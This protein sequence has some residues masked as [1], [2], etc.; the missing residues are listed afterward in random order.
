MSVR[1]SAQVKSID[2]KPGDSLRINWTYLDQKANDGEG[3]YEF[4]MSI[5]FNLRR[6]T[7]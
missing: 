1:I 6:R 7:S 2:L 5:F 3:G 4:F